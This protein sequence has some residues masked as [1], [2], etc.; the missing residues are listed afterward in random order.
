METGV[1]IIANF[2]RVG[3]R[4]YPEDTWDMEKLIKN[5]DEL[6]KFMIE[7]HKKDASNFNN[8]P[9][10]GSIYSGD[11]T[12][13]QRKWVIIDG[14][15]YISTVEIEIDDLPM[16]E[17]AKNRYDALRKRMLVTIPYLRKVS[18]LKETEKKEKMLL[19]KLKE[20]YDK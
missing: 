19:Q 18:T 10:Y 12:F 13:F 16:F 7:I 20:K 1:E 5:E 11:F 9:L 15:K 8:Y 4:D 2:S 17:N 6:Y 14:E 3:R